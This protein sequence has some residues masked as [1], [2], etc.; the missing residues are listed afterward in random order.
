M[1]SL[2]GIGNLEAHHAKADRHGRF[3]HDHFTLGSFHRSGD[4]D[5]VA[6]LV[7]AVADG[8]HLGVGNFPQGRTISAE[9]LEKLLVKFCVDLAHIRR[10]DGMRESAGA[11]DGHAA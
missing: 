6:D 5:P 11:E 10:A 4:R 2:G 9:S 1:K 3:V 8:V 7:S